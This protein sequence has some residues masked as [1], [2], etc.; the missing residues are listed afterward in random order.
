MQKTKTKEIKLVVPGEQAMAE[1]LGQRDELL[2][3]VETEFDTD[4]MVRGNEIR[5][6]GS[7]AE[8]DAA[9]AIFGELIEIISSGETINRVQVEQAIDVVRGDEMISPKM[10]AKETILI[11]K[12]TSIRPKTPGQKRYVDAIGANTATFAIGPAGTG[13]TY[14]AMATA[15][16]ALKSKEVGRI[17]LTRPAVE[18]GEKL[19]YLPGTLFEKVEPYLKPL[20]D[21]LF[22]M[23]DPEQYQKLLDRGTIE[24]APLAFMRGR[25]LNNSFIILDEA[26]NTSPEQMKMFL[27]RLGFRSKVVVTG[28]VT[29]IDLPKGRRSGL[30]VTEQILSGL[31]GL[32]FIHLTGKDVVRHKLVQR[33][34]EAYGR[35]EE[36][37][38]DGE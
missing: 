26:Q 15:I 27:T 19:G 7:T 14:L 23:I 35:Y 28:D 17:I 18:A 32:D 24:V 8:T 37:G 3:V 5:I 9:A 25:T 13:K 16:R 21:A 36:S 34:V 1:L 10:L 33:I 22:D 30:L 31:E 38:K 2:K 12:G 11:H 4:I 6:K 20:Y 29:Q